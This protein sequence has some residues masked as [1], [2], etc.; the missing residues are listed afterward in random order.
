MLMNS[1]KILIS[2]SIIASDLSVLGE[3]VKEFDPKIVDLLHIDVMDGNFVPNITIGP[4]YT[5]LLQQHTTIP[6]DVHLMIDNPDISIDQYID[7][8]PWCITIHYESTKFPVRLARLIQDSNIKSGLSINPATPV[9]S[10]LDLLPHFD[11]ILIMSVDPGFYGQS[12][13]ETSLKKIE[14]LSKYI[15][16]H[17][18]N[19][20]LIQ[21][22]GGINNENISKVVSA[23][24]NVIVSGSTVFNNGKINKN[25]EELKKNALIAS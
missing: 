4:G 15:D 7:L 20:T 3:Q 12:F 14:K 2:P 10:I 8:K 24:A 18:F 9:E 16:D 5:K 11:M 21:V 1:N 13:M 22:D 23:G 25:T 17:G 19:D 6:F